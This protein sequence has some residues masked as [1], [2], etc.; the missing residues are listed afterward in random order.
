MRPTTGGAM[1]DF[2]CIT[3]A[4]IS[5]RFSRRSSRAGSRKARG[6]KRS[7]VIGV[8]TPPRLGIGAS[9]RRRWVWR[10][11]LRTISRVGATWARA[12]GVRRTRA[13]RRR[14]RV[15][16]ALVV[17]VLA[18]AGV[19]WSAY[20]GLLTASAIAAGVGYLLLLVTLGFFIWL[21]RAG[22]WSAA[23][24]KQLIAITV[25]FMA[26]TACWSLFEQAGSTLNLFAQRS[27]RNE[28][29]GLAFPASWWQSLN[30]LYIILLAPLMAWLWV[31]LGTSDPSSQTKFT[32]WLLFAAAGFGVRVS[33]MWLALVYLLHTVGELCLSPIGLSAMT[34]LAPAR[35]AGLV[36]GVWFL[37]TSVGIYLGGQMASLYESFALPTLF[38]TITVVAL[39]ATLLMTAAVRPLARMISHK[40]N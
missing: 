26:A 24:R 3:S 38:T 40:S 11:G 30:S 10:S 17:F 28:I 19:L 9:P 22:T 15:Y 32:L 29:A 18:V 2:R 1:R 4:S 37:A 14:R 39:I 16:A 33:P 13:T 36:M 25:L 23:E 20:H 5:A 21:F 35:I 8:S 34:R 31:R 7:C 12:S 6:S 27:T